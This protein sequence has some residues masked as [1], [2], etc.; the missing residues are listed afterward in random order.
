MNEKQ[1]VSKGYHFTGS[2]SHDKEEQKQEALK[3]RGQ[4]FKAM[5]LTTHPDTLS[6]GHHGDGYSVY[7]EQKY[8]DSERLF[9]TQ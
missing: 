5:V 4:G 1:A 9:S 3:I 6:R 2:Y 8:F 7:A